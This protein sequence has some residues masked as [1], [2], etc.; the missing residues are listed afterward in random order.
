MAVYTAS[1][2]SSSYKYVSSNIPMSIG[3]TSISLVNA[4]VDSKI[5]L[6]HF[7][8]RKGKKV[9]INFNNINSSSS[10]EIRINGCKRV[11]VFD[12]EHSDYMERYWSELNSFTFVPSRSTSGTWNSFAS[13][14][15][16]EISSIEVMSANLNGT[17]P[18]IDIIVLC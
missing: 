13:Y 9:L 11:T 12:E 2:D 6:T 7:F 10:V 14:G 18:S 4:E 3:E 16:L 5:D 15:D 8:G 17:S 1:L